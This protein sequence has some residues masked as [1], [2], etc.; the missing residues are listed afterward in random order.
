MS[1]NDRRHAIQRKH[2]GSKLKKSKCDFKRN[3]VLH[4]YYKSAL[5]SPPSTKIAEIWLLSASFILHL[6]CT[7][8]LHNKV[9]DLVNVRRSMPNPLSC[10]GRD[11]NHVT[12]GTQ[13]MSFRRKKNKKPV[14]P[15]I[16]IG[17]FWTYSSFSNKKWTLRLSKTNFFLL[18]K[19]TSWKIGNKLPCVSYEIK[20]HSISICKA[21]N[22]ETYNFLKYCWRA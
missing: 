18:S 15:T 17:R 13:A 16:T 1:K 10:M 6:Q 14:P 3:S 12:A 21:S 9:F 2:L 20:C 11:L 8:V 22:S 7:D 19:Q 5:F 4:S